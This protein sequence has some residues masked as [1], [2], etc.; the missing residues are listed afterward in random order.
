M[1]KMH[2]QIIFLFCLALFCVGSLQG[3]AG[4]PGRYLIYSQQPAKEW[5]DGF[6][7]GNGLLGAMVLGDPASDRIALNHGW[8]WR[9]SAERR[10]IKVAEKLPEF[11]RL[12][13]AGRL[14]DAGR[15]MED[16]LMTDGRQEVSL[17]QSLSAAG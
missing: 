6:P 8:L 12:F 13:L 7:I 4:D 11:R 2:V 15:L 9:R 17:R 5:I 10:E 1:T 14:E 3:G 16:D